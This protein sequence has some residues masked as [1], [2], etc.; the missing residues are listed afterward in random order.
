MEWEKNGF[1]ISTD[2]SRL[3]RRAIH[4]FLRSSYWARGIPRAVVDR[5]LDHALCF[6]LYEGTRQIGLARV[7]TDHATFA[8]LSD[9]YVLPSHRGRGLAVWLMEVVF[10]HPELQGLRRWMLATRDA[11]GLYRK[12]GFRDLAHPEWLMEMVQADLYGGAG[13][14]DVRR[15]G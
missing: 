9:V 15:D 6:G 12:F 2:R 8:Y 1:L 13:E 10:A 7:I 4:E 3:D 14:S 5:S 11:H